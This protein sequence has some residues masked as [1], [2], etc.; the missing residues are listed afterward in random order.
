M[1][2][3]LILKGFFLL[4]ALGI[5]DFASAESLNNQ[6]RPMPLS[7]KEKLAMQNFSRIMNNP[8]NKAS[9]EIVNKSWDNFSLSQKRAILDY[10]A[11]Q[12]I[13]PKNEVRNW[14]MGLAPRGNMGG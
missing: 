5:I 12:G 14:N 11:D 6:R 1:N 13:L 3:N 7:N 4:A 8:W 2:K 9:Q 10:M